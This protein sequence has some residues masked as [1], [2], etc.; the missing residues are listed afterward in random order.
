MRAVV[1]VTRTYRSSTVE[2]DMM[3][4]AGLARIDFVTRAD[5]QERQVLL[6]AAFP[7]EVRAERAT[8]EIQ[9]GAVERPTHRNTSWEQEKFEVCGHRW[10]D[11]SEAG[12]GVSLLNDC[13]YGY[14]VHGNVLRLT[15]LRGPEWPDP[16]ADRGRHEFTYSLLPHAGDWRAGETVRRAWELNVPVVS[17]PAGASAVGRTPADSRS[18]LAIEGPGVLEALK[19]AENG[20]GWIVRVSEPHGG[21]GRVMVRVPRKLARVEACNH[22]EEGSEPVAHDGAAFHFPIL[23]FQVRTFRLRFA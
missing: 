10:A 18:F 7:L 12:Y 6:K 1:R 11:L 15:L 5:W 19:R 17:V 23:P 14:D 3:V 2:Q 9:F 21:R 20:D 16:D 22:V 13:K 8:Y 4:W